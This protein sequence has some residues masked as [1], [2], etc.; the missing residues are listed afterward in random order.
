MVF[1]SLLLGTDMSVL[2]NSSSLSTDVR[3][4]LMTE[5]YFSLKFY[6]GL[7]LAL[8]CC[9]TVVGLVA[10]YTAWSMISAIS[11]ANCNTMLRSSMGQ[12]V[13]AMPSRFVVSS[14]YLFL[15][16]LTLLLIELVSGPWILAI[17]AVVV[18]LFF[19]VVVSLSAFG[20][21]VV[22]T[23]AMG[24]KRILDPE[25]ERQL[26][27]SGLHAS[28]LIKATERSRRR[29]SVTEQYRYSANAPSQRQEYF[30]QSSLG[31]IDIGSTGHGTG[32]PTQSHRGSVETTSSNG[33]L[34]SFSSSVPP[35]PSTLHQM[36][37]EE[38]RAV[39]HADRVFGGESQGSLPQFSGAPDLP[40]MPPPTHR[41]QGSED[42]S[43]D[44]HTNQIFFPR[45]SVLNRT[46]NHEL[47]TVVNE[48]LS[49]RSTGELSEI[50][51]QASAELQRRT[52]AT[53]VPDG[54]GNLGTQ[55][56]ED[57]PRTAV[58]KLAAQRSRLVSEDNVKLQAEWEAEDDVRHVY[59]IEPPVEIFSGAELEENNNAAMR[60]P[61]VSLL[62]RTRRLGSLR[63]L[64]EPFSSFTR[65]RSDRIIRLDQIEETYSAEDLT[66]PG[67]DG[68][69]NGESV[70]RKSAD[71]EESHGER[72]YLL[73]GKVTDNS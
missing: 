49:T 25:F 66:T 11:D 52:S 45:A 35:A 62:N 59:D 50:F 48:A 65:T 46:G 42:Y 47:K 14:L 56:I 30:G 51:E 43:V 34:S 1:L 26:L 53:Q 29:T 32:Q 6:I 9:V 3:Q 60:F 61:R 28:L 2:M 54:T 10:T 39:E 18:S 20:R 4:A 22:H 68:V 71:D 8:A 21:L 67:W 72:Q 70:R 64:V 19:Q 37:A 36:S 17:V 55:Q 13:T 73:S 12:Y 23:G 41:R 7:V 44:E 31:S 63:Q 69:M 5:E 33:L 40:V 15:V 58:R 38:A 57:T 24:K 27:P 16:W